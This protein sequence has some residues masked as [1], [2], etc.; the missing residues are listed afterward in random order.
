MISEYFS[1]VTEILQADFKAAEKQPQRGRLISI[2]QDRLLRPFLPSNIRLGSGFVVD[3]K[4]RQAGPFDCVVSHGSWPSFGQGEAG[5][6]LADGVQFCLSVRDWS[7]SDLT[8]F[9]EAATAVQG[10]YRQ[11]GSPIPCLAFSFGDLP[12][13]EVQ[14]FMKS[15]QG[16]AVDAVYS[17]GKALVVRNRFGWYGDSATV[18]F[19]TERAGPASLK[20]FTFYM[21]QTVHAA[22][23]QPF[24]LADYQHL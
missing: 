1:S 4:E 2:V 14:E 6:W 19:V 16:Q 11:G 13:G 9:A 23:G 10:L 8:Q 18:P 12:L 15:P 21:M 22:M 3:I 5:V 17:L 7:Q 24:P 20:A